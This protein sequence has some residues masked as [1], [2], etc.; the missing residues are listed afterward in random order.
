MMAYRFIWVLV[1][2]NQ[3]GWSATLM[4]ILLSFWLGDQQKGFWMYPAYAMFYLGISQVLSSFL[5][6]LF[7][8]SIQKKLKQGIYGYWIGVLVYFGILTLLFTSIDFGVTPNNRVL[9][10]VLATSTAMLLG[11]YLIRSLH[12]IKNS[13]RS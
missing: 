6:F 5:P 8:K 10:R 12:L 11:A 9:I 3:L 4:I 13:L 1:R 7:W 2:L